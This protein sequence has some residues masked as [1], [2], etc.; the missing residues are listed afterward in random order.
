MERPF[1]PIA[2][3]TPEDTLTVGAT[4]QNMTAAHPDLQPAINDIQTYI[5]VLQKENERL[6]YEST[7]DPLTGLSNRRGFFEEAEKALYKIQPQDG[8]QLYLA[9]L[10]DFKPLNDKF[11]H[12]VGDAAL[13]AFSQAFSTEPV[14]AYVA[15]FGGDEF[16][17]LQ[18]IESG[19]LWSDEA[20]VDI[21]RPAFR[22]EHIL[23]ITVES[24][25]DNFT[26]DDQTVSFGAAIGKSRLYRAGDLPH[27]FGNAQNLLDDLLR[28]ADANMYQQKGRRPQKSRI[29][30]RIEE[31]PAESEEAA[32][33]AAQGKLF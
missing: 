28:E 10:N 5:A 3:S 16:A 20:N 7:H 19:S 15:R 32:G 14:G 24:T 23:R 11:G 33:L 9:D 31:M 17:R 21:R 4:L 2:T 13:R 30:H 6:K 12:D 8:V 25:C 29:R 18:I 27:T 1:F 26:V 22:L